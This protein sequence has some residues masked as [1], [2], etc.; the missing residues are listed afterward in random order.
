MTKKTMVVNSRNNKQ[1]RT[2]YLTF[3]YLAA[4]R[5]T[6]LPPL[7]H[8][9]VWFFSFTKF[10][11]PLLDLN[12]L[13]WNPNCY[14]IHAHQHAHIPLI[15][16]PP[17]TSQPLLPT[18]FHTRSFYHL[19]PFWFHFKTSCSFLFTLSSSYINSPSLL[20]FLSLLDS[21][22]SLDSSLFLDSSSPLDYSSPLE[23]PSPLDFSTSLNT[24]HPSCLASSRPSEV[25]ITFQ[26]LHS[27]IS[28]LWKQLNPSK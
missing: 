21:P 25:S 9:Y 17:F 16:Q 7:L 5:A 3:N 26:T 10:Q 22:S 18:N 27:P 24:L 23:S 13:Q 4:H 12:L 11:L 20:D 1:H 28:F 6:S 15:N 8:W 19:L 14:D 2:T